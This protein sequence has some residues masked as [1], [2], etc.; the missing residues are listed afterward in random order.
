MGVYLKNLK[1]PETCFECPLC[2]DYLFCIVDEDLKA[3][4]YDRHPTCPL[5]E[6]EEWNSYSNGKMY[7]PKGTF[8]KILDDCEEDEVKEKD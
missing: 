7:V 3:H 2:Y 6:L 5:I 4:A 8:Q 1:V